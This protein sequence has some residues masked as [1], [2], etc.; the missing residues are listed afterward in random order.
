M[1]AAGVPTTVRLTCPRCKVLRQFISVDGGVSQRCGGCEWFFTLATQ[2]PTGTT[3]AVRTA[4]AATIPVA[5]GGA[6]FTIGMFV[7]VDV[8]AL[9][10]VVQATATGSAT[11]V[12]CTPYLKGHASGVAI[13]QLLVG[14]T[15]SGVGEDAVP[16]AAGWGF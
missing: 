13:G 12:P 10:E 1:A 5:S 3:N 6:S 4:G 8:G 16:A 14:P 2:A 9:A 7:L 11:S 15:Y